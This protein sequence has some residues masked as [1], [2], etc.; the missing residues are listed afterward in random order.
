MKQGRRLF[1]HVGLPKTASSS[2]QT[3]ASEN[4]E[5]LQGCNVQYPI[6]NVTSEMPKHQDLVVALQRGDPGC[7]DAYLAQ[8]TLPSLFLS[9]EGLTN[10]LYDF[11][12][13][14]LSAFRDRLSGWCVTVLLVVR[15]I[16]AWITS[17]WKQSML[18]PRIDRFAYGS[19]LHRNDFAMLPR[20]KRLCDTNQVIADVQ[21]AYG[22]RK[23]VV[24]DQSADWFSPVRNAL[25]LSENVPQPRR[26][27]ISISDDLAEVVRQINGLDLPRPLHSAVLSLLQDVCQTRHTNLRAHFRQTPPAV[28]ATQTD[29]LD[30]VV[31]LLIPVTA[32][33]RDIVAATAQRLDALARGEQS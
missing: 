23:V 13:E 24:A 31:R 8:A 26:I 19:A 25:G 22:A 5:L 17:F 4:R 9:T 28:L 11:P 18:N 1:L 33:Q 20:I 3:W 12:P 2:L 29:A 32:G 30:R 14:S 7:L 10:H 15:P 6:P 21:N 16:E 27:H